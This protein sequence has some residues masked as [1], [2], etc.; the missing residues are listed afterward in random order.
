MIS[1]ELLRWYPFFGAFNDEQQKE[2]AMISEEIT[3]KKGDILFNKGDKAAFLYV[4]IEGS[5]DLYGFVSSEHDPTFYKEFLAGEMETGSIIGISALI[6][7][8]ILT[9]SAKVM[10]HSR[11]IKIDAIDLHRFC[12]DD[13]QFGYS[14]MKQVAR[15]AMNRLDSTRGLLAAMFAEW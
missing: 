4:L 1:P 7:P 11:L 5:V 12:E 15:L 6:E 3:A 2:I 8:Y 10:D 13:P 14:L 9:L